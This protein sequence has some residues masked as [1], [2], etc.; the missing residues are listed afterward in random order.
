MKEPW[1]YLG[2]NGTEEKRGWGKL[3]EKRGR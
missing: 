1:E 2:R 3:V